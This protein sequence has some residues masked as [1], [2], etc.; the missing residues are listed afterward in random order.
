[1][2]ERDPYYD[3][4][5]G[6]PRRG[7]GSDEA[8][9][10]SYYRE[11]DANADETPPPM[12]PA[13][14]PGAASLRA[15]API[16]RQDTFPTGDGTIAAE[17]PNVEGY[18]VL[19]GIGRGGMGVVYKAR[20]H[21][22]KRLVAL[23]MISEARHIGPTAVKR[24]LNEA[25][26]VAGLQ[27]PNIVQVYELGRHKEQPYLAMELV[28][29][30]HLGERIRN[31]SFT[32][33]E[34]TQL[35]E[36]LARAVHY[37]HDR[38]IVHR[39]LKPSNVLF[40]REGVPKIADF[41]LA[42]RLDQES[43]LTPDTAVLGTP[44]YMA[45][46]QAA[47][48]TR[49]IG[50]SADIHALGVMLYELLT[51]KRP[52][53]SDSDVN[54]LQKIVGEEPAPPSSV[55]RGIPRDL[56]TIC[57]KCLQK[58]P[59][60]RYASALE[61]AEDLRRYRQGETITARRTPLPV[62]FG[63]WA[64]RH[65]AVSAVSGVVVILGLVWGG[66][67][68]AR[69]INYERETIEYY[70][71]ATLRWDVWTGVGRISEEEAR[72]RFFSVRITRRGRKGPIIRAAY[73]NGHLQLHPY[74]QTRG[75][76]SPAVSGETPR[77]E[78]VRE[79]EY[80]DDGSLYKER[81]YDYTGKHLWT[82]QFTSRNQGFYVDDAGSVLTGR[83]GAAGMKF[84]FDEN[85]FSH[86]ERFLDAGGNPKPD[87]DGTFGWTGQ[88]D[89]RGLL[90]EL[91]FVDADGQPMLHRDGYATVKSQYDEQGNVTEV[92]YFGLDG[93][94]A[95]HKDGYSKMVHA[96]GKSGNLAS[97]T[98]FGIDGK[99]ITNRQGYHK[100]RFKYNGYGDLIKWAAY[101]VDG[102][103]TTTSEGYS[104]GT[105]RYDDR[106]L[107]TETHYLDVDD[108]PTRHRD[109]YAGWKAQYDAEGQQ[110]ELTYLDI[111]G[112]P[113][114]DK[115]GV[116]IYRIEY[117][118]RGNNTRRSYFDA[119]DNPTAHSDGNHAIEREYNQRGKITEVRYLDANGHL[120]SINSGYARRVSKFDEQG[121]EIERRFY[122]ESSTTPTFDTNRVAIIRYEYDEQTGDEIKRSFF[123][124][125]GKPIRNNE[126]VAGWTS[127]YEYGRE[128]RRTYFDENGEPTLH[129]DGNGAWKDE[130]DA[131]GRRVSRTF[132]GRD[133]K[134]VMTRYGYASYRLEYDDRGNMI[135]SAYF[136][137]NGE[138][139]R[140]KDG[141]TAWKDDYNAQ[142]RRVSRTFLGVDI[143]RH[144]SPSIRLHYDEQGRVT[145]RVYLNRRGQPMMVPPGYAIIRYE[146]DG[147][148]NSVRPWYFD[149]EGEPVPVNVTVTA[150]LPGGFGD[151]IGL[152]RGD[153]FVRYDGRPVTDA[154]SFI[155]RRTQEQSDRQR[156]LV[157]R[158]GEELL[159]YPV[160]RGKLS[161]RLT[162]IAKAKFAGLFANPT[163]TQENQAD[164]AS[165]QQ[166]AN[167]ASRKP[168]E[169][170]LPAR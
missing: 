89:E 18:D 8:T 100:L 121:N 38:G 61:L 159:E 118:A 152:R 167:R 76:V 132:L 79:Y 142:G 9:T 48:R 168:V 17:L 77:Y 42:K 99:P 139:T 40:S 126:N 166:P 29:G 116:A 105:A 93:K 164:T 12:P 119:Q 148:G 6:S 84:N 122:D 97:T 138:P 149:T 58:M 117:D 146:Y 104:A 140:N 127:E 46:E 131:Q 141:Y 162:D 101:G 11:T 15:D 5:V 27:H 28:E 124:V 16:P 134:P 56:E 136:D 92:A 4:T 81:A 114:S 135:K 106:G 145:K 73:V 165:N 64:R 44:G 51:G 87:V 111:H 163:P 82:W 34:A 156:I 47:G 154:T 109:G 102:A 90:L 13:A 133:G 19:Q 23:K 91:T 62:R 65:A 21:Q 112:E 50:P 14:G 95:L 68:L 78:A 130:Y 80:H 107:M 85:G 70:R 128:I 125:D 170:P 59:D 54:L 55:R 147:E 144:G 115:Y 24:F 71:N 31:R 66:M 60:N 25:E 108:Q 74:M 20:H 3:P 36:T 160:P 41:G 30:G 83:A 67:R 35:I 7:D 110:N 150:V 2:T 39:D 94:P 49:E 69:Y 158:R 37:A 151:Q 75:T 88:R 143:R 32:F 53:Q 153:V 157:V 96:Y 86:G 103:R 45:P 155:H 129:K 169:A 57:L 43:T 161:V 52:F 1:M 26:F 72:Q 10:E 137:E 33:D 98:Y 123:G 120:V 113:Q 63:R 22:L